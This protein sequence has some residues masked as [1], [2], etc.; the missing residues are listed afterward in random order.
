MMQ[1]GGPAG[2][3]AMDM[4]KNQMSYMIPNMV[5]MAGMSYF[6]SGFVIARVPFPLTPRFKM[7][8]QQGIN[9]Q[10]LD[11]SYVSAL[12]WYFLVMF[13]IRGVMGLFLGGLANF[14]D[15]QAMQMQMQM[16]MGA[17]PGAQFDAKK[18]YK[19]ERDN[20]RVAQHMHF[21]AE[22][23]RRLVGMEEKQ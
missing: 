18:Q 4:M 6:F 20:F 15:M 2:G 11:P 3:G 13:G 16:G 19:D 12:S 8:L 5:M 10:S 14:Q 23:E 1:Q 22:A 17:Q 7:M 21:A 9:L